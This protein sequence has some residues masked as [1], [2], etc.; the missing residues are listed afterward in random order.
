MVYGEGGREEEA[1][2]TFMKQ[3]ERLFNLLELRPCLAT[4]R[5]KARNFKKSSSPDVPVQLGLGLAGSIPCPLRWAI[6]RESV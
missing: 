3:R 1:K 4:S 5:W 2:I 6:T